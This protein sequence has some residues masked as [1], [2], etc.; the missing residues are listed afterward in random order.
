MFLWIQRLI[1]VDM[2]LYIQKQDV[3]PNIHYLSNP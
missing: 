1:Q 2:E 3:F